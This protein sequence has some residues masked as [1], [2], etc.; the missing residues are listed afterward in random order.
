MLI[1]GDWII[2]CRVQVIHF[3]SILYYIILNINIYK[4][5]YFKGKRQQGHLQ[6]F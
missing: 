4:P 3:L 2:Q 5:V 1:K 6:L